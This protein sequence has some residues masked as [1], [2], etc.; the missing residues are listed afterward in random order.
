M[1][2]GN[3]RVVRPRLADAKFFFDQDRKHKLETR[4]EKLRQ[5]FTTTSSAPPAAARGTHAKLA[6]EIAAAPAT[7][8]RH[9]RSGAYLAKTDL[10]T[11]HGRRVSPEL[12]GIMG[13]HYAR[14]DG[15]TAA[16]AQTQWNNTTGRVFAATAC[17][18]TTRRLCALADKLETLVGIWG[19]GLQ[20][21]GDKDPFG[22]RRAALGVL[23]ILLETRCR[24]IWWNCWKSPKPASLEVKLADDTVSGLFDFMLDRLRNYLTSRDFA[25]DV[26]E[27]VIA[28]KP[29]PHRPGCHGL[30]PCA[31]SAPC[32]KPRH[33]RQ[34]TSAS[35]IS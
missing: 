17:L 21:T 11:G 32:R 24:W 31:P 7:P 20:P 16:V 18:P 14:H 3:E 1:I 15:E 10:V 23:R 22:L 30:K 27:A 19:I 13:G 29:R 25:A 2:T 6:G 34:P 33:W 4:L 35:A 5:W 9:R 12:Q 28:Q 8:I 26:V